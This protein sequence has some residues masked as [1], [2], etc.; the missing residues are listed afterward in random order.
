MSN[1]R[2]NQENL[3]RQKDNGSRDGRR[4]RH[5]FHQ[6]RV[7]VRLHQGVSFLARIEYEYDV[8]FGA[9]AN[10]DYLFGRRRPAFAPL[11]WSVKVTLK[12]QFIGSCR[13][14]IDKETTAQI[15]LCAAIKGDPSRVMPTYIRDPGR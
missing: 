6:Y 8:Y 9:V 10:C 1:S 4:R 14:R 12:S 5:F 2:P 11:W 13:Q 7:W 3:E 15:H